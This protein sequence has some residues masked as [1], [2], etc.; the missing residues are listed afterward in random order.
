MMFLGTTRKAAEI[1]PE[2]QWNAISL[3]DFKSSSVFTGLAYGYLWFSIA[4]SL[5]VYGVDIFTA[6]NLLAFNQWSSSIEP[7]QLL[8]FDETKWIFAGTI[9]ASFVNL[10]F[11]HL[12]AWRVMKRGSVAEC[13][14]DTLAVRLESVR[15]G[16][17]QGWRR[18][19]VFA[20][21]TKSKKGAEYVALF[22]YFS[23]QSWIRVLVCS[24]PRQAVNALTLYGVYTLNLTPTDDSSFES[25]IGGFFS[26]IRALAAENTQQAVILSGMLFT[27]V[28]WI[29]SFLFL[30]LGILFYVFFLWHYIPRQDGG[31]HG[32]CERK[33]N[34]RLK[35]IV[36][37]K[38]NKALA[39]EDL[40]RARANG[41]AAKSTGEH[42][43]LEREAT[44]PSFMDVEK[45][46]ALPE[47]PMLNRNDTM[48]TLPM[49][50]SRPG[51]PGSIELGMLDQKRPPPTRQATN[52]TS[53]SANSYSSRAPLVAGAAE[54]GYDRSASPAPTIPNIDLSGFQG[55]PRLGT[56]GSNGGFS[57]EPSVNGLRSPDT[58][59]SMPE[60]VRS[61]ASGPDR[62]NAPSSYAINERNLPSRLP[63]NEGRSIAGPPGYASRGPRSSPAPS[64]YQSPGLNGPGYPPARTI[65]Y[66]PAST[67]ATFTVLHS[68]WHPGEEAVQRML[69]VPSRSNP[70]VHGLKQAH[71]YRVNVSPLVAFGT[72]DE[73]GR[74]WA[75]IW[76]GEAGF[77]RPI[78]EDVLGVNGIADTRYDPVMQALF[79]TRGNTVKPDDERSELEE[80][81]II[82]EEVIRPEGGKVMAGLSI[83]LETR[84]RVKLAGRFIAGSATVTAPGVANLQMAFAVEE[85]LG[86]CPKYL[87]KKHIVPHVPTPELVRGTDSSPNNGLPLPQEAVD[88]IAKADLFFIAR[89]LRIFRNRESETNSDGADDGGGVV[90]V[91]PEY[92]GN[93]LY[94][95][96]GNLNLDPVA[97]LVIPDFQT[98]DVLYLTGRTTTLVAESAAAY[99]P[100]AKLAVRIDVTEARFVR[101]GLPFR[102]S[103]IDYSPYNPPVRPL[104]TEMKEGQEGETTNAIA[105]ATLLTR[106]IITPTVSRYTFKLTPTKSASG[107]GLRAWYPGQHVTFDFSPELDHG[108][109]HMRDEDPQSL[110][111][112]FVRTFTVSAP[113]NPRDLVQS[114]T[115]TG[116]E[117]GEVSV[118]SELRDGAE[119]ELEIVVRRHGSATALLANWNLRVPLEIP[120]LGFGGV[121]DFRMPVA[122]AVRNAEDNKESIFIAGGV[123]ITPL[124]AQALGVLGAD[125]EKEKGRLQVLW[126]LRAEDLP[127]AV[128]A[129]TKIHGLGPVTKL[130]VTGSLGDV[131]EGRDL[132][133]TVKDLGA[134]VVEKRMTKGDVLET[135][136]KGKRKFFCCT[137]PAMMKNLLQW[138]EGEDVVFESFEY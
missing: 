50:T 82:D 63:Y 66:S 21:L 134:K 56:P 41:K 38:I 23:L 45:G 52:V 36:T 104:A 128:D 53:V 99:M 91:Y 71:G 64:G 103:V 113:L 137:G 28:I 116:G 107:N 70:T 8:T 16:K 122:R 117:G 120:V 76:G 35:G 69:G 136:E 47:M 77:C 74:P 119:P 92:S 26:N 33:V 6:I 58:L 89:F 65:A 55:P 133:N 72:L 20:E 85:A 126:S 124:L 48:A 27:L 110:N 93:R 79:A 24:G 118:T 81:R 54:M 61:P 78:A 34:K 88:L 1:Q 67:M 7:S 135:G 84:D 3:R 94:Q 19:L 83:D 132:V 5:A 40:K 90:L 115:K 123:G 37:K 44:L 73:H 106:Q 30:L 59:Q 49:Y 39:K 98:S 102:G 101:G 100:R 87:N 17:G 10:I 68:Q 12:R 112:D 42:S 11:E 9:I 2:E 109:S 127:L 121:E 62:F 105:M 96:L 95:T 130:F 31:L 46:D 14:L 29:F 86:N 32:Y 97:G 80:R 60:R 131:G 15:I 125:D 57:R 129:F 138:M 114:E 75:T 111:D 108:Y 22:S 25:T 43:S 51:T 4:L 13:Y 18:F